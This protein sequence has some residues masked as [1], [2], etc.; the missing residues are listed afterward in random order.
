MNHVQWSWTNIVHA[1]SNL[2]RTMIRCN[3]IINSRS[4][5]WHDKNY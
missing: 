1:S 3:Q 4:E 5:Q 2:E